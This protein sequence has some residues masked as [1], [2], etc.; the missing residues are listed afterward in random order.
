MT[1]K[2]K[3]NES[4]WQIQTKRKSLANPNKTKV[5]GKSKQNESHW[6]IQTKRKSMAN[7]N[8]TKAP[9]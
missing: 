4:H 2:S 8:K 7:P 5:I 9:G 3:Q 1:G 6:Q